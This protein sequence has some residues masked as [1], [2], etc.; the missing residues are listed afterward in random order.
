LCVGQETVILSFV[1]GIFAT[2][3]KF[4][5]GAVFTAPQH[6]SCVEAAHIARAVNDHMDFLGL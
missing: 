2:T 5:F 4:G 3:S 1:F 6:C